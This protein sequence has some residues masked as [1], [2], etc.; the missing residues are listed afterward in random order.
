LRLQ[1]TWTDGRTDGRTDR[2]IPIYPP[3]NFV[4]GGMK[5]TTN[6]D[7]ILSKLAEKLKDNENSLVVASLKFEQIMNIFI[8]LCMIGVSCSPSREITHVKCII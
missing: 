6:L 8:A 1:G 2:V 7:I 3:P 5:I 4:C